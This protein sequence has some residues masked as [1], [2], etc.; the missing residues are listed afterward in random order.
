MDGATGG[1]WGGG[2]LGNENDQPRH[3]LMVLGAGFSRPAGLPLADQLLDLVLTELERFFGEETHLHRA[4]HAYKEFLRECTGD[5]AEKIDIE[6][7]AAYL[8]YR[9]SFGVLGSDTWSGAG[10]RDQLLLRWGIGRVL[11]GLT[12]P[13]GQLPGLYL[14][15]AERL[16][17]RDVVLT[18]NYDLVL[19]RSLEAVGKKFRRFPSRFSEVSPSLGTVDTETASEEVTVLKPHGSIDWVDR[20]PY[21]EKLDYVAKAAGPG[22]DGRRF[23]EEQDPLFGPEGCSPTHKLVEG[24]R[25]EDD[26]LERIEVIDDLDAYYAHRFVAFQHAPVVLA[27]SE[28]KQL[29]G[30]A[31]RDLWSGLAAFRFGWGGVSFLGYSLPTADPYAQLVLYEVIR[32]YMV[33]LAD[34]GWRVGPM[35]SIGL[36]DMRTDA[37]GTAELRSRYRF[38][39]SEHT[40]E[41]L[42]GFDH[43]SLDV[44][45]P[46][47]PLVRPKPRIR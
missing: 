23:S 15:F 28:A 12:P 37:A 47:T 8:D 7:F 26:P 20:A 29:Y 5:D 44:V 43:A 14:E 19:E 10:N 22:V 34:P 41:Y 16:A 45:L 46:T 1:Q 9:H 17:P 39:P 2:H 27:P 30:T 40:T 18:F 35:A 25:L 3:R 4:L 6:A 13:A 33:G 42:D 11:H 31:L 24:P 21:L 38:L 36:V 32:G